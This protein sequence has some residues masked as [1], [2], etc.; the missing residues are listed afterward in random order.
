MDN[1]PTASFQIFDGAVTLYGFGVNHTNQS[2]NWSLK[3][4]ERESNF[5][6][7]HGHVIEALRL[8]SGAQ[9]IYAP[10]PDK[11]NSIVLSDRDF[12]THPSYVLSVNIDKA[13]RRGIKADGYGPMSPSDAFAVSAAD[14]AVIVVQAEELFF[15]AHAGRDS[16]FDR[17]LISTGKASKVNASVVDA[18]MAR[19]PKELHEKTRV[20]VGF[21]I[22]QGPHFEHPT[23]HKN[24]GKSNEQ[25]LDAIASCYF[26][27][28]Q[29]ETFG[30][31]F[32]KRGQLDM[33]WLI[34]KQF[35]TYGVTR[36]ETDKFCTFSSTDDQ[37]RHLWFSQRRTNGM[38][39]LF[40]AVRNH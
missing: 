15:A 39:N 34:E 26:P 24:Y 35:Q 7:T 32:W 14:C 33:K 1:R 2:L 28:H 8:L 40:A 10:S 38:R 4:I 12:V 13:L 23:D 22:S 18:I 25:L 27:S 36:F 19:I 31:D 21:T 16:L 9:R 37:G 20:F 6:V 30:D 3:G 5:R 11:F 29:D 17:Q